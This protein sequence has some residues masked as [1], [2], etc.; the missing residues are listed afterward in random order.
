MLVMNK[1][2]SYDSVLVTN[3]LLALANEKGIILNT[4]E[5]QKLRIKI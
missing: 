2:K 5:F 3:Y 4:T 1:N